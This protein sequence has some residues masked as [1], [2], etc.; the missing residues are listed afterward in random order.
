MAVVVVVWVFVCWQQ[1]QQQE[2]VCDVS[3]VAAAGWEVRFLQRNDLLLSVPSLMF[4][5]Y[6]IQLMYSW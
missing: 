5:S 4:S 6:F 3:L 2:V 1:Q